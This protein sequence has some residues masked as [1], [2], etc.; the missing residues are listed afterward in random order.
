[1]FLIFKDSQLLGYTYEKLALAAF[2]KVCKNHGTTVTYRVVSDE[3][4]QKIPLVMTRDHIE[5]L[6]TWYSRQPEHTCWYHHYIRLNTKLITAISMEFRREV[7]KEYY[8][9]FL[10][11]LTED[12]ADL[13]DEA[14]HKPE[15]HGYPFSARA[16]RKKRFFEEQARRFGRY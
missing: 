2:M 4:P 3:T 8:D 5:N 11:D 7:H 15:P 16:K 12:I 14:L 9:L 1:M 13:M 6:V 10:K